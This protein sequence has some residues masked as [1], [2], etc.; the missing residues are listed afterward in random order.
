MEENT[1]YREE[2]V[3]RV[4]TGIMLLNESEISDVIFAALDKYREMFP[5]WEIMLLTT[6]KGA[7]PM[8]TYSKLVELLQQH[9]RSFAEEKSASLG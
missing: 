9:E 2:L 3:F 7:D 6:K 5:D 4:R 8:I 1:Y